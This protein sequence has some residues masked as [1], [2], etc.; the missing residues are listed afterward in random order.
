MIFS[1]VVPP[2]FVDGGNAQDLVLQFD[3]T[4]SAG[5]EMNLDVVVYELGSTTAIITDTVAVP[6]GTAAR[7][8]SGL[9]TLLNG[10]GAVAGIDAD[11]VLI[12]SVSPVSDND[13]CNVFGARLKYRCGIQA[14]Q[15]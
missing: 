1:M 5:E 14:T 6:N 7:T 9:A 8:W 2:T 13:D 4:E 11:D 15:S 3:I 12:I 10:I